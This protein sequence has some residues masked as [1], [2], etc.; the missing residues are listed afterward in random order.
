V[1][2]SI[3]FEVRNERTSFQHTFERNITIIKG[4]SATGKSTMV[5]MVRNYENLGRQSG[6]KLSCDHPCHVLEGYDW[7][8]RLQNIHDSLVFIDEGNNFVRSE[9]FAGAIPSTDNYYVIS[10]RDPLFTLPY[11]IDSVFEIVT[12]GKKHTF[13]KLF[14]GD[15]I[16]DFYAVDF[17][18]VVT[19]DA[20]S[21]YQ[22]FKK[23]AGFLHREAFSAAGKSN[24][25]P[26]IE[27]YE[28]K[29]LLMIADAAALGPEMT[30]LQQYQDMHPDEIFFMLPESF[31]WMILKS[32]LLRKDEIRRILE[33]P[34]DYIE[35]REYLSWEQ[36]F[37]DLLIKST[38][39]DDLMRYSKSK[40]ADFYMNR[41]NTDKILQVLKR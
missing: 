20:Q 37:T 3:R 19:E 22:F 25:L 39:D 4:H 26:T 11:S 15:R 34:S 21:G 8:N 16:S 7:E 9:A 33:H 2:G 14:E 1:K 38:K 29:K 35:S 17:D 40:L 32:G 5:N 30:G 41:V 36:F 31:E 24:L 28:G 13:Q 10:V 18:I 12:K 6:V 23:A 27:K